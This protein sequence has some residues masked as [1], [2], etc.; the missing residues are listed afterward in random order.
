M[1]TDSAMPA[2]NILFLTGDVST[3]FDVPEH[4]IEASNHAIEDSCDNLYTL[5]YAA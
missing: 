1:P 3:L 4:A 2:D 5:P